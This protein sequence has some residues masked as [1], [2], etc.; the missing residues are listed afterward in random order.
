MRLT[1]I[2]RIIQTE[3]SEEKLRKIGDTNT[4]K[5]QIVFFKLFL[6][7]ITALM[8]FMR[9]TAEKIRGHRV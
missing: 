7:K 8:K 6:K 9:D 5:K 2:L 1:K 4:N 3:V